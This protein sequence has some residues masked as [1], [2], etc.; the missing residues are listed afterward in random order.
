MKK[1]SS[2]LGKLTRVGIKVQLGVAV[3]SLDLSAKAVLVRLATAG[4]QGHQA[5]ECEEPEV[6]SLVAEDRV[7][8]GK[9]KRLREALSSEVERLNVAEVFG[10]PDGQ[11]SGG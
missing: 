3:G 10:V 11:P 1:Q 7:H 6:L 8:L 9:L 4:Q 5:E 2:E